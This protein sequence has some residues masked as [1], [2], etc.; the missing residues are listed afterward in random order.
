MSLAPASHGILRAPLCSPLG[1]TL[2]LAPSSPS[3]RLYEQTPNIHPPLPWGNT[4]YQI[5]RLADSQRL[6]VTRRHGRLGPKGLLLTLLLHEMGSLLLPLL[7]LAEPSLTLIQMLLS[8]LSLLL[9]LL[10]MRFYVVVDRATVIFAFMLL[11]DDLTHVTVG[12]HRC[13]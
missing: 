3:S 1:A 8:L 9:S 4:R 10:K 6:H 13:W 2:P 5:R 11:T 12:M 7:F